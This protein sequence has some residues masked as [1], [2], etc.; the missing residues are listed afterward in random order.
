MHNPVAFYVLLHQRLS[1]G[2]GKFGA[3]SV[4]RHSD[5]AAESYYGGWVGY[6]F[7]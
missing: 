5:S 1:R 4:D 7:L 6:N 2:V 3:R